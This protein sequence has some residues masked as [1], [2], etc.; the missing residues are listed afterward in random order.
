MR[1]Q[2]FR[3]LKNFGYL[4]VS[5]IFLILAIVCCLAG[6]LRKRNPKSVIFGVSPLIS[7]IY[8]AD[9]LNS[10]GWNAETWMSNSLKILPHKAFNVDFSERYGRLAPLAMGVYFFKVLIRPTIVVTTCEGFLIGQ[11]LLWRLEAPLLRLSGS[12]TVVIPYG[13][14]S[15]SYKRMS[16]TLLQQAIQFSYPRAARM[17]KKIE[18]RVDYWTRQADVF[19]PG[20]MYLDGFGRADLLTPSPFCINTE[21]WISPQRSSNDCLNKALVITHTPNHQGFKGTS[22]LVK[23]VERLQNQGYAVELRLIENKSNAEVKRIL[24]EESD[25]HVD[26]LIAD[27]YAFSAIEG[28]AVGVPVLANL[29][30]KEFTWPLCNWS[31]LDQCPIVSANADTIFDELLQLIENQELRL[32][33]GQQSFEYV[34]KYHS[35]PAF[36]YLFE[37]ICDELEFGLGTLRNLYKVP[38]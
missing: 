24:I 7:N 33:I 1:I 8:W 12:S 20:V 35:Y 26:Q 23:A 10:H 22:F 30:R 38:S 16:S 27:G 29:S 9:A 2:I 11:S 5:P 3:T 21:S 25:I 34:Q 14:D 6:R 18:R 36:S 31:F 19:I 4:F 13:G 17:Q 15:Y 28:M 32:R 37:A